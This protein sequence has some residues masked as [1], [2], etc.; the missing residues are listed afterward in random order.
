MLDNDEGEVPLRTLILLAACLAAAPAYAGKRAQCSV[1]GG[2][3]G[4]TVIRFASQADLAEEEREAA[5]KE[6]RE[7]VIDTLSPT[8]A[9]RV[10][11]S[12]T[13]EALARLDGFELT[14]EVEGSSPRTLQ[15]PTSA[16]V[17][18]PPPAGGMFSST[19]DTPAPNAESFRVFVVDTRQKVE[20]G[21]EIT[22][23]TGTVKKAHR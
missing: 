17:T 14:I 23:A 13:S 2:V 3:G 20:C 19:W 8:G 10:E 6:G 4:W 9:V 12:R 21:A 16:A 15:G 18:P 22:P 7:P 11:V 1:M 5:E